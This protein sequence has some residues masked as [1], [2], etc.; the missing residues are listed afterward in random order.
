[1]L[2]SA[3]GLRVLC[4]VV[5]AS[6][7]A[8]DGNRFWLV[9]F[10]DITE[11]QRQTEKL[12]LQATHDA[13]TGL[14][15]RTGLNEL[16]ESVLRGGAERV[17]VLFCDLDNF[18]RVNDALGH[19]VGDELLVAVARRLADGLPPGCTPARLSGDEYLIVCSDVEALGGL[20]SFTTWVSELLRT[21]VSLRGQM[22][23]VSAS[24]GA[25]RLD[26]ETTGTNLLRYADTAMF[27]A[28]SKGPG[29]I[30][31]ASSALISAMEKQ[32]GLE[33]QLREALDTDSLT[34]YYQPI[35]GHEGAVIMAEALVRWPHP[36]RGLLSPAVILPVAEQGNLLRALDRWVLH[37]A[38]REA[39]AWPA[40]RGHPVSVA[41]NLVE[42]L[43]HDPEFVDEITVAITETGIDLFQ[44]WHFS[45][46]LPATEFHAYLHAE[47]PP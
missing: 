16:L 27:H 33:G 19:E 10:Q 6:S 35:L 1:M 39:A 17:A 45:H 15:N 46:A 38:L 30:S 8:D 2:L 47:I 11:W 25:A 13:L 40:P 37:T 4:E 5:S 31:L 14:L 21:T 3:E 36:A 22:V 9:L 20:E 43:P 42:L 28:K 12:R 23:T 41:I 18:K 44:G 34:L 7:V 29:R 32:L 24:V 26:A